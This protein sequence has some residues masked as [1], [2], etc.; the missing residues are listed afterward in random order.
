LKSWASEAVLLDVLALAAEFST[1]GRTLGVVCG[2]RLLM[3]VK[4][5]DTDLIVPVEF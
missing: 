1:S 5:R 2:G 3:V 4:D